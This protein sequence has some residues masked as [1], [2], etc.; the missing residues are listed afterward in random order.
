[1]E[2]DISF[3][4]LNVQFKVSYL[5]REW[6]HGA[7]TARELNEALSSLQVVGKLC[8]YKEQKVPVTLKSLKEEDI[9]YEFLWIN[10]SI[11][12]L[13]LKNDEYYYSIILSHLKEVIRQITIDFA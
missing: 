8:G 1:M 12:H 7:I 11:Y 3:A 2:R 6:G 9:V 13:K 10:A 4:L 5:A